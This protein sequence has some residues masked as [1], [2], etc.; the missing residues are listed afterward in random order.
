LTIQQPARRASR[1]RTLGW[2]FALEAALVASLIA[3]E[4]GDSWLVLPLTLLQLPG[5]LTATVVSSLVGGSFTASTVRFAAI[6]GVVNVP[7]L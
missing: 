2:A 4:R 6:V 7:V 5:W 3:A 1:L